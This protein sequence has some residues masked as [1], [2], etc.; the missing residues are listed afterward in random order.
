MVNTLDT[1]KQTR[2]NTII[3]IGEVLPAASLIYHAGSPDPHIWMDVALWSECTDIVAGYLANYDPEHADDYRSRAM[4]Y[5]ET[6]LE[7]H[8]YIRTITAS[9]PPKNRS[10]ITAHDAFSYFGRSYDIAVYGIQGISTVSEASIERVNE[11]V[12]F[13][14]NNQI[15]SIF[16]ETSVPDRYVRALIEGSAAQGHT[17]AIGGTLFSDA[18]GKIGTYRGSYIGMLDHNATVITRSLRGDAPEGGFQNLLTR[19]IKDE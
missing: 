17:L 10:M 18:M 8:A 7:L 3:A 13:I 5:K 14:T 15:P 16:V 1:L 6:L 2:P 4:T 9:I 11:L 19:E 12:Q